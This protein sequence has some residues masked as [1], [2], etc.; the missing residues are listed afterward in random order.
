M[1]TDKRQDPRLQYPIRYAIANDKGKLIHAAQG[2]FMR[3]TREEA[4]KYLDAIIKNNSPEVLEMTYNCEPGHLE[5]RA[6][7]CY[8]GHFDPTGIYALDKE[9]EPEDGPAQ[10][11][12]SAEA[13][14]ADPLKIAADAL[15]YAIGYLEH[16]DVKSITDKMALPCNINLLR[17]SIPQL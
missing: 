7:R 14:D 2:R 15:E 1:S 12:E 8:P 4:Q 9:E 13:A 3:E 17:S 10:E 5:V 11:T 6:F 16:P